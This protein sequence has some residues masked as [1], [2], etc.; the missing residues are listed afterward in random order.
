MV[1]MGTAGQTSQDS[2]STVGVDDKPRVPLIVSSE[3]AAAHQHERFADYPPAPK[4]SIPRH[5]R[6][7]LTDLTDGGD[8]PEGN[9]SSTAAEATAEAS[10]QQA[11]IIQSADQYPIGIFCEFCKLVKPLRTKHCHSC[12]RC[13][14]GHDHHCPWIGACVGPHNRLPFTL[15]TSF[16]L[17]AFLQGTFYLLSAM[18]IFSLLE[19]ALLFTFLFI[20]LLVSFVTGTQLVAVIMGSNTYEMH[21][22][23]LYPRLLNTLARLRARSDRPGR[24]PNKPSA[25]R[26][27]V[28]TISAGVGRLVA[29]CAEAKW[30]VT[31]PPQDDRYLYTYGRAELDECHA[32]QD[33]LY[34]GRQVRT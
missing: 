28:S 31:G 6:R 25:I 2:T 8:A 17:L 13:V 22:M 34:Q 33:E 26:S 18:N 11:P 4:K 9:V 16:M 30:M 10:A 7:G 5:H 29:F 14:M 20:I 21:R 19:W 15:L 3:D 27:A 24:K 1:G 32:L 23:S 12:G